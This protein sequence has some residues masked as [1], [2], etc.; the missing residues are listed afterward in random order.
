MPAA[1]EYGEVRAIE[2][3]PVVGEQSSRE[4]LDQRRVGVDDR[5]AGVADDVDVFVLGRSVRRRAV[6]EMRVPHEPDLLEQFKRSVDGGH[7][8]A[9]DRLA[10]LL[11][12]RVPEGADGI[13]HLLA[14][15]RHPQPE[16][17]Q[18]DGELARRRRA[19][20]RSLLRSH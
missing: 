15:W 3:E 2:H 11:R 18:P 20:V 8:D 16:F 10:D 19:G 7:V 5:A 4:R 1:A 9:V 17:A 13:E 14:L 12:R 6:P